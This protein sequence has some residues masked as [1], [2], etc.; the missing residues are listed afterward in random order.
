MIASLKIT[1]E[2]GDAKLIEVLFERDDFGRYIS[3]EDSPLDTQ[4][5]IWK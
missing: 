2:S 4:I 1:P 3:I 5:T